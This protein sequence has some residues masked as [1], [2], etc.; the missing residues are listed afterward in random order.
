[1][2]DRSRVSANGPDRADAALLRGAGSTAPGRAPGRPRRQLSKRF[3]NNPSPGAKTVT[4]SSGK[5]S[6]VGFCSRAEGN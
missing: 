5:G 4:S 2:A 3:Q 6:S 1:M